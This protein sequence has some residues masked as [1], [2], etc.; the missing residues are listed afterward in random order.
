VVSAR[1]RRTL[2]LPWLWL[3]GL[4][5]ALLAGGVLP[6]SAEGLDSTTSAFLAGARDRALHN[7]GWR[8]E[9][10]SY[11]AG[12]TRLLSTP[13][14]VGSPCPSAVACTVSNG[15]VFLNMIPDDEHLLDYVLNHEFIHAMEYARGSSEGTIGATLA[16]VLVLSKD[17]SFP[18]AAS[19]ARRVLEL[20]GIDDH[21]VI[22]GRDWFHIE[23][24][25]LGDVGWDVANL[26]GWY[27]EAY[28]PYLSPGPAARKSI[29]QTPISPQ[30]DTDM[31]IQRVLDTIVSMCGPVLPGA[32][33]TS[34]TV[35]CGP[36]PLWSG[37][38]YAAM[39]GGFAPSP[40]SRPAGPP[41][42]KPATTTASPARPPDALVASIHPM[43]VADNPASVTNPTTDDGDQS[44]ENLVGG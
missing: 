23:H 9:P 22:T 11:I 14:G 4:F 43:P 18:V 13:G 30:R 38:P 27:R 10:M 33:L 44:T 1:T 21:P 34:P 42:E 17:T 15:T 40:P 6:A 8:P 19:A 12:H 28:F 41:Q 7:Y 24:D 26:P 5:V 16:D 29:A 3:L 25:I 2:T 37:V 39:T 20:S 35:T 31:R 32:R 36:R